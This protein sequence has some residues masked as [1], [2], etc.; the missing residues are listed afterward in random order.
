[1]DAT[2]YKKT[3]TLIYLTTYGFIKH[4]AFFGI[5]AIIKDWNIEK[6]RLSYGSGHYDNKPVVLMKNV[7][8]YNTS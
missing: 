1:M 3:G 6:S 7:K 4:T 5:N 2:K 8:I